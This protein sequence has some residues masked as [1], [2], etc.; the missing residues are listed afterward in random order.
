MP[1]ALKACNEFANLLDKVNVAENTGDL[2]TALKLCIEALSHAPEHI[3]LRCHAG[4]LLAEQGRLEEAEKLLLD[5]LARQPESV[6]F[7]RNLAELLASQGRYSEA[8]K[9]GRDLIW[10]LRKDTEFRMGYSSWL[11]KMS[12]KPGTLTRE[13]IAELWDELNANEKAI[14]DEWLVE[15]ENNRK[16]NAGPVAPNTAYIS[17]LFDCYAEGFDE[18]LVQLNYCAPEKLKALIE[19]AMPGRVGL[20]VIDLGCGTGLSGDV[21]RPWARRLTGIDCSG[22]MIIR[23]KRRGIYDLLIESDMIAVLKSM[24]PQSVDLIMVADVLVYTGDLREVFIQASR[25]LKPG[26]CFAATVEKF[27]NGESDG[28]YVLRQTRRYAHS[29]NYVRR[30]IGASLMDV[31]RWKPSSH[32]MKEKT[33]QRRSV[34]SRR[35][36]KITSSIP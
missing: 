27:Q 24:P 26:G 14:E 7:A 6:S 3:K 4:V 35:R 31:Y 17:S 20:D 19:K 16:P 1:Q 30:M 23:A 12:E 33:K 5:G 10:P 2:K 9:L 22:R 8:L 21:L 13:Q 34:S 18:H 29:E 25:V 11:M 36:N 15:L 32:A 28:E